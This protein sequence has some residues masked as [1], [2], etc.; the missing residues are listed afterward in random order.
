MSK[1]RT[2]SG[3]TRSTLGRRQW[4]AASAATLVVAFDPVRG[5]WLPAARA[6]DGALRVPALD[7]EL[8]FEA[9]ALAEAADDFGH[10]VHRTPW[11]VLR[12]RSARDVQRM[13]RFANRHRLSICMRGQ[14]HSTQGQ[15]QAE[16]GVVIDSRG[17]DAIESIG[18][19]GARVGAGVRWI[20]LLEAT[21]ERGLTP[22]VFTDFIELSVGGTLSVGGIGGATQRHG[23][24]VDNVL[25]LEVVTGGG[26]RVTCSP[27]R[28]RAL[29]EA[30]LGGLGQC[31]IIVG[32]TLRLVAAP[33]SARV[34]QLFYA[35]LEAF[36]RDQRRA[37]R[38]GRFDYLEGQVLTQPDGSFQFLLEAAAYFSQ[39]ALPDDAALLAGLT[40]IEGA[41]L[42]D[43]RR[44][45][46]WQN[47]LA[48]LIETLRASGA[49]DVPHPWLNLFLPAR[50]ADDFVQGVLDAL[51]PEDTG[52]G[53]ILCYPFRRAALTRPFVAMPDADVV[54]IF[55]LL[56]FAP[57]DP[58]AVQALLEQNRVLYE[59]ARD[60]GGKRYAIDSVPFTPEDWRDH[61]GERFAA[62]AA[63]RARFDPNGVLTPGQQIFPR[64]ESP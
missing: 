64:G 17:L 38:D 33:E 28:R 30:V 4:L 27:R 45:F 16:G 12:A 19:E 26:E 6:H 14:G 20:D 23:L 43:D 54:V 46:D 47:R 50:S 15:A 63:L 44:Y 13:L 39:P 24:Q 49:W 35:D 2:I 40:P 7:G 62:F 51:G 59:L 36:T 52:G 61:F 58:A 10:I 31:A 53:P 11:A 9:G 41:T 34:Y 55:G 3:S 1:S 5:E 56:R 60:A 42:V 32:A 18:P 37:L 48:P 57:P 29:F 22:P 8:V 21:L 25:E